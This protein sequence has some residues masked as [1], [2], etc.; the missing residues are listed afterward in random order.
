MA[1]ALEFAGYP[2]LRVLKLEDSPLIPQALIF[3]KNSEF[4]KIFNHQ[5]LRMMEFGLLKNELNV[6]NSRRPRETYSSDLVEGQAFA[7]GY[8]NVFFPCVVLLFGVILSAV[9]A[10]LE[11]LNPSKRFASL[12][13]SNMRS[14]SLRRP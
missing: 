6:I 12:S 1:A 11:W 7:I 13:G 9:L 2:N 4:L 5:L 8:E 10:V 3:T 14:S